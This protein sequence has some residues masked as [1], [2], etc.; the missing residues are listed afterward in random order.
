MDSTVVLE[1][2][3]P[4]IYAIFLVWLTTG[5]ISAAEHLFPGPPFDSTP[6]DLARPTTVD[7]RKATAVNVQGRIFYIDKQLYQLFECYFH[8]DFLQSQSFQNY[9]MDRIIETSQH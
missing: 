6:I 4:E 7:L 2:D 3:D 1:E 9:I 8:G 5:T